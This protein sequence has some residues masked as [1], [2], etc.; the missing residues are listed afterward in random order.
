[1]TCWKRLASNGGQV[2]HPLS[3][4]LPRVKTRGYTPRPLMRLHPSL[5]IR[6][7]VGRGLIP[8]LRGLRAREAAGQA[9][10]LVAGGLDVVVD[11]DGIG[12]P[13]SVEVAIDLGR[14]HG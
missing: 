11:D 9:D 10:D 14:D 5:V 13:G 2:L 7:C 6:A 12:E 4:G 3:G 1:M 8:I